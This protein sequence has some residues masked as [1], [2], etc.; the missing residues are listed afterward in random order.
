MKPMMKKIKK[1]GQIVIKFMKSSKQ[2]SQPVVS[3]LTKLDSA[4]KEFQETLDLAKAGGKSPSQVSVSI[5][6]SL[7]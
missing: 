2:N 5:D 4:W 3:M 1:N 7:K 6:Y